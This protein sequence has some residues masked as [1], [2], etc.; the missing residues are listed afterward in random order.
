[1]TVLFSAMGPLLLAWCVELT[2]SYAMAFY[3]LAVAVVTLGAAATAVRIPLAA[4]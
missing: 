2:G 3:I 1:M 4:R